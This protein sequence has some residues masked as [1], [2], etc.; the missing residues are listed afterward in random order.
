MSAS[1][2][3]DNKNSND[4]C[5]PVFNICFVKRPQNMAVDYLHGVLYHYASYEPIQTTVDSSFV[6]LS[7]DQ[8]AIE[9]T[10]DMMKLVQSGQQYEHQIENAEKEMEIWYPD[11]Y[12]TAYSKGEYRRAKKERDD[13]Q[14]HLDNIKER[15]KKQFASIKS[16]QSSLESGASLKMGDFNG[17]KVYHKFKSFNGATTVDGFGEFIF[18][19]DEDFNKMSAYPKEDYDAIAKILTAISSSTDIPEM[20]EKL[21]DEIY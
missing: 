9:L 13:N 20:A 16:R 5:Y 11:A 1:H 19:C 15:I 2:K 17:W 18:F 12:S 3:T 14:R 21:Q 7:T 4:Y 6:A 8:E 10:L